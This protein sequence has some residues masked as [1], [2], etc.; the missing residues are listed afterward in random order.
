MAPLRPDNP[1]WRF[2]LALYAAPGVQPACLTLQD[3]HGVDVNLALFCAWAGAARG[4]VLAVEEIAEADALVA[5]WR[6]ALVAPLRAMRRAVKAMP[7]LADPAVAAF[8]RH[9]AATELEAERIGQAMLFRWAEA[10]WPAARGGD[11]AAAALANLRALAARHGA[12][13]DPALALIA[14]AAEGLSAP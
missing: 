6:D 1:F 2:S 3:R 13:A 11:R 7:A 14:E 9:V 8:R 5:P 12:A 10:R 4:V